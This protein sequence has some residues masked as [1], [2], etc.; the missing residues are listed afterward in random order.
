MK[1]SLKWNIT[2]VTKDSDLNE[3]FDPKRLSAV[4]P[5]F[6]HVYNHYFHTSSSPKPLSTCGA[7]MGRGGTT[8]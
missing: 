1:T 5:R 7:S 6:I 8:V 3:Y 2:R 4:A